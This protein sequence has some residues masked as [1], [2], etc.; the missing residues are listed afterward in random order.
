MGVRVKQKPKARMGRPEKPFDW[1]LLGKL[2]QLPIRAEDIGYTM[3]LSVDTI[4]R[5]I[6]ES[7]NVTFA[8]Y[9]EQKRSRLR[10][11]LMGK[12]FETAMG[13]NVTMM[14]WLGKNYLDQKDKVDHPPPPPP[15]NNFFQMSGMLN[16]EIEARIAQLEG[17]AKSKPKP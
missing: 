15:S 6:K 17:N 16:A 9:L 2:A 11:S 7:L 12:Q 3:D 8:E 14:I 10:S 1:E 13:G 5:R 4:S